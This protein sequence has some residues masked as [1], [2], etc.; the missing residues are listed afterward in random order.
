MTEKIQEILTSV[1]SV[2]PSPAAVT[3]LSKLVAK[4]QSRVADMITVIKTDP[5]LT[6][7]FL[8]VRNATFDDSFESKFD[9]DETLTRIATRDICGLVAKKSILELRHQVDSNYPFKRESIW[10]HALATALLMDSLASREGEK[11]RSTYAL[12]LFH[13][14]GQ[15]ILMQCS[16]LQEKIEVGASPVNAQSI[17]EWERTVYGSD[18]TEVGAE[19]LQSWGFPNE[20]HSPVRYQHRPLDAPERLPE[21]CLLNLSL[22]LSSGISDPGR[23]ETMIADVAADVLAPTGLEPKDLAAALPVAESR[24]TETGRLLKQL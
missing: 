2:P 13:S 8:R 11:T 14:V 7:S 18:H 3:K 9:L 23:Y 20:I 17:L 21:T 22:N 15:L 12:G 5:S 10:S 4:E 24:L 16:D 6:L 1:S 19:A